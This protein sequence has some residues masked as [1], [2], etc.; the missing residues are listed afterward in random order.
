MS[1]VQSERITDPAR[2]V[3]LLH[4]LAKAR[5]TLAVH[6]GHQSTEAL[7]VLL[8]VR[9][10]PPALEFDAFSDPLRHKGIATGSRLHVLGR[11]D[12]VA[13]RF[14]CEVTDV[15]TAD[16]GALYR[17]RLPALV[18]YQE[19]RATLRVRPAVTPHLHA[20]LMGGEQGFRTELLDLSLDGVALAA[21][22]DLAASYEV[23]DRIALCMIP[24][25]GEGVIEGQLEVRH[26][27]PMARHRHLV[28]GARFVNLL[29]ATQQTL[30]GFLFELQR[31]VLQERER[32]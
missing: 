17:T 32:D 30:Q 4:R 1:T 28:I 22:A 11:L 6:S 25:P 5:S 13:V 20:T 27:T 3:R 21:H 26:V 31:R 24:L 8:D 14:E 15:E 18:H 16:G 10:D 12:G 19:R 7:S 2:V 9:L 23:G 29:T